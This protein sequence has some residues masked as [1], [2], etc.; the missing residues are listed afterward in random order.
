M[1]ITS[2]AIGRMGE[3]GVITVLQGKTLRVEATPR[4]QC[5]QTITI[6]GSP[7]GGTFTLTCRGQTTSALSCYATAADVQDALQALSTVGADNVTVYGGPGPSVP[8]VVMFD[9]ELL[10]A[11][12]A[13]MTASSSLTGGSTPAI[14]IAVSSAGGLVLASGSWTAACQLRTDYAD[15]AASTVLALTCSVSSGT[16]VCTATAAATDAITD[17][18]GKYEIEATNSGTGEVIRVAAGTWQ[19]DQT[20]VR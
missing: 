11:E 17:L 9:G 13:Q 2:D 8:Y 12:V 14:T 1:T 7:T 10:G 6:S 18:E 16:V 5:I 20:V 4:T 3:D 19:L 15:T